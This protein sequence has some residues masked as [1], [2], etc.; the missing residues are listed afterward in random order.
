M[1][2]SIVIPTWN[3]YDLLSAC[4]ES[5]KAQSQ[6]ADE[7]IVV[8]DASTDDTVE[9]ITEEHP[10]ITLIMR[11]RNGGFAK[12]ANLGLKAA[13]SEW[14]LL[15]NNDMTLAP[16]FLAQLLAVASEDVQMVAPL[17]LWRDDPETIYSAGDRLCINGRPEAIG[18]REVRD[19]FTLPD[20]IFGVSGGSGL[21]HRTVFERVGY[22]DE[23]FI[24]Y[25]EDADL[26]MRARLA[27]FKACHAPE[28]IA[29][30][31]GSASI[32]DRTWWRSA[33][34]YRNHTLLLV[35]NM[36]GSLLFK[37]FFAI[38][39]EQFHQMKQCFSAA[40]CEF[41]ALRASGITLKVFGSL[42]LTLIPAWVA[43]LQIQRHRAITVAEFDA[44]LH[45]ARKR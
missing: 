17:V 1:K 30:H 20:S 43:R 15:L 42:F 38:K 10:D 40:R 31:V 37:H 25:F 13:Q 44:L 29:Y 45:G 2:L 18:F 21:F 28:A 12:A 7:I 16:D 34:C 35:K 27:G 24:A 4:L 5:L 9:R 22:L 23:S 3:H 14:V 36:P 39:L 41:G 32:A 26:A 19:T 11:E 6:P 8:N 33:Q